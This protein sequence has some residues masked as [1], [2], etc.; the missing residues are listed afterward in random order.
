M[1]GEV[2]DSAAFIVQVID[3]YS[4][5]LLHTSYYTL[6]GFG[7]RH[8]PCAI[9]VVSMIASKL[10]PA[11]WRPRMACSRPGPRPFTSIW[12]DW[13]PKLETWLMARSAATLAAYGVDFLAPLK[14]D[15]PAL[16]HASTWPFGSVMETIVLFSVAEMHARALGTLRLVFLTL[17]LPAGEAETAASTFGP[18]KDARSSAAVFLGG[19]WSAMDALKMEN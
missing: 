14:P 11:T 17:R 19:A 5:F 7:A 12:S 8:P 13:M 4:Y 16:A 18:S 1:R 6:R 10:R 3:R 15:D 9:G 2:I